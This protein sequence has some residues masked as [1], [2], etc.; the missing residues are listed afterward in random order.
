MTPIYWAFVSV[1]TINSLLIGV[2][3]GA[4]FSPES[5]D[6]PNPPGLEF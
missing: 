1:L 4:V 6:G 5:S 3:M 2:L